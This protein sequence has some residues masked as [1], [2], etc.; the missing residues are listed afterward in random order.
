MLSSAPRSSRATPRSPPPT[1]SLALRSVSALSTR[2]AG[3]QGVL[4]TLCP[5]P[6]LWAFAQAVPLPPAASAPPSPCYLLLAFG[7]WFQVASLASSGGPSLTW[8]SLPP[9]RQ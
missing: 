3:L 6:M 5:H 2:R 1:T 9:S 7:P 8:P 4:C